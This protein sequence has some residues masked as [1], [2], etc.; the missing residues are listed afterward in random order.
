VASFGTAAPF[1]GTT[2]H[3]DD[4]RAHPLEA[5]AAP[6]A[7]PR[8]PSTVPFTG[9]ST[10]KGDFQACRSPWVVPGRAGWG[11]FRRVRL[12]RGSAVARRCAAEAR[13]GCGGGAVG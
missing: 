5:K 13:S 8:A 10:Y 1:Q 9:V 4:F 3:R 12:L 11:G 6:A 7:P 2:T